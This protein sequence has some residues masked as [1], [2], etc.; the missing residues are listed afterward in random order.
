MPTIV[1][2][3]EFRKLIG[4]TPFS[5]IIGLLKKKFTKEINPDEVIE[6]IGERQRISTVPLQVWKDRVLLA[7]IGG[8]SGNSKVGV[9]QAFAENYL[10]FYICSNRI[11][12]C[13]KDR[14][15]LLDRLN[16]IFK[17]TKGFRKKV[18]SDFIYMEGGSEIKKTNSKSM[19]FKYSSP[20]LFN[21]F[22]QL[23]NSLYQGFIQ[24]GEEKKIFNWKW[25]LWNFVF[26]III[27]AIFWYSN[28]RVAYIVEEK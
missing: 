15:W 21:F 16:E 4:Q 5:E 24:E 13:C 25:P 11:E 10:D 6:L 12:D 20:L 28:R 17:L 26:W 27:F 2:S 14:K 8:W 1:L 22:I 7:F 23:S 18:S 9:F 3:I 19:A